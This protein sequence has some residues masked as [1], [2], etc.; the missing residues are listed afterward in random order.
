MDHTGLEDRLQREID[1]AVHHNRDIYSAVLGVAS[2]SG[3]FR[4]A[5]AAGTAYAG[6]RKPMPDDE[7]PTDPR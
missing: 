1:G 7:G 3:D 5:G 2:A 4:W 6:A